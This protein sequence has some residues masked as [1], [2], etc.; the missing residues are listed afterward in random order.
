[1]VRLRMAALWC[2]V[3]LF[4]GVV[5]AQTKRSVK[6]PLAGFDAYVQDG[7]TK[8]KG[9]GLAIAIVKNDSIVY[10]K[11]FGVK[12]LGEAAPVT[13]RTIFA[14]GSTTK[15]FTT[16]A[17]GMLVDEGRFGWDTRA[18]DLLKG[19]EVS[20]P[21][22]TRE[23]TVRDLV[24]HR[25]GLSRGDY[26]WMGSDLSRAEVLRRVRFHQ[27]TWSIRTTFGYQNIMYL[28][29]GEIIP[30]VT[31]R[32]WDDF[33]RDR[34]FLPLGMTSTTTTV[35]GLDRQPDVATPHT[36]IDGQLM[37]IAYRQID[38][39]GPAGS[40]NSNVMDM[41]QW[42]R[43]HLNGGTVGGRPLLSP[44]T[45]QE[46]FVTQMWMRVGAE[47]ALLYPGA[48]FLGYGLG[49]FLFDHAGR[50]VVEH[51]GGIDGM[52]TE[53]MM[54]PSEKLGVI[55]LTNNSA[56][57]AAFPIARAV[58]NRYLGVDQDPVAAIAPLMQVMASA[59]KKME[60]SVTRARVVG[61]GPSAALTAYTGIFD[62]PMHGPARVTVENGNLVVALDARSDAVDLT[63]WHYDTFR[64]ASRDKRLGK[65]WVNFRFGTDG[66]VA[67][68]TIDGLEQDF[69]RRS[70]EVIATS[71]DPSSADRSRLA[72]QASPYDSTAIHV[73]GHQAKICYSRP[74]MRG[75]TVFGSTLVPYDSLWRTGANDPTILHLPFAA[76]IAGMKVPAGKYS[77]YTVPGRDRWTLVLNRS[78]SQG[79]STRDEGQFKSA[80]TPDVR[81][82]ELG[83]APVP[84]EAIGEAVEK[85]TIRSAA[86]GAATTE[87]IFEWEKTRVRIPISAAKP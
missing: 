65:T 54:V 19:F 80:Y 46:M 50:K 76:E 27:P 26:L 85:F 82:Q 2:C 31:G 12:K 64:A 74:S 87:L 58:L 86:A 1:M 42:I 18:T 79:G 51:S 8:L 68:L 3:V 34:I 40:I 5:E 20:D 35:R 59:A 28:A 11:G 24:T 60:D 22:V 61:K 62:N 73:G 10:A 9:V 16:A 45:H 36:E 14:V 7:L 83:R 55:V 52:T 75:R 43:F 84:A 72:T 48:N 15:A 25:S 33:L 21:K 69:V 30:A 13:P 37:P 47:T 63:H 4:P 57:V 66:S 23:I 6:D 29:A 39:I 70:A 81:A 32:S 41:A 44:A 56:S 77:V 71:C 78:I 38:N 17:L 49:W 67:A 53:L